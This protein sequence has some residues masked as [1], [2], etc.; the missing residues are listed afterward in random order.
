MSINLE[1][2]P[3][4]EFD[5]LV[6]HA[7]QGMSKLRD[8]VTVRN[9]VTGDSYDFRKMGKGLAKT[10]AV[11]DDVVPMDVA[12]T[13]QTATLSNYHAAEY[14]DI[15]ADAEVNFDEQNELAMTIA[16]ALG[17]RMDQLIID[18]C[19]ASTPDA[20]DIAAGGTNL[21]VAK[22]IDAQVAL[23]DQGV[24]N[25]ELCAVIEANGLG[26]LLNDEKATSADYMAV[27][28]LIQGDINTFC[29]FNVKVIESRDEGGLTE[30]ANIVDSWFFHKAAL[31]LAI[32]LDFR[33][34]VAYIDQKTSWLATGIM[35]AG[36]VVRDT[37][38][39]V[40]VLYDK[41]A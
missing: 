39:L 7:Y 19:D 26:G 32:G 23:R 6:K 11:Q 12:H 28:A 34:R 41:T 13:V 35:K 1:N 8:A 9:G 17:R 33:T 24:P 18:A 3:A 37:G 21:T 27:K 38:G 16:G 40:K 31:G 36:S 29:G 25:S 15:F 30:A 20:T 10:K 4:K 5:S 22:M 14:T 2:V